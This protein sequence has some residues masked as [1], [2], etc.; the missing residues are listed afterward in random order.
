MHDDAP[1]QMHDD[2]PGHMHYDAPGKMHDDAPSCE[3]HASTSAPRVLACSSHEGALLDACS[4][5][6]QPP[7][8][9]A[10]YVRQCNSTLGCS[11]LPKP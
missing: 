7:T 11:S 6:T 5:P 3:E 4:C 10:A 1:G 8:T 2:A 9:G